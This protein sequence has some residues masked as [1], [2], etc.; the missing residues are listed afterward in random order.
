LAFAPT[1]NYTVALD[2]AN[3]T[4]AAV[5]G[6]ATLGG[7]T[8]N[9]DYASGTFVAKQY[10]I[11]T[12]AGGVNGTFG[13]TVNTNLPTNFTSS[14]SYDADDVFL[15]LKLAFV[16]PTGITRNQNNVGNTIVNFFNTTGSIPLAF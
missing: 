7:A 4:H 3:A 9:A 13:T 1:A 15:N 16:S 2:P 5:S 8:V 12:A 10:T 11:L 6:A 14:L